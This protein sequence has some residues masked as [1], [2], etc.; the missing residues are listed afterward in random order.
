[1]AEENIVSIRNLAGAEAGT[2]LRKFYGVLDSYYPDERQFGTFVVLNFKD[3]EVVESTE[4]YNFPIATISIKL[5]NRKNS[6]WGVF[7]QSLAELL[8]PD[9]DIKDCV[10]KRMGLYMEEG[11]VFGKDRATGED[12]VGSVWHCFEVEGAAS[13]GV[14][15]ADRAKEL[16]DGKTKAEF[17]KAAY[18]DP[19]IRKDVA[20]QRAITDKSFINSL[21]QTGEFVE[22]ENG[23]FH[24]AGK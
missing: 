9:Q 24:K 10:G 22:D 19:I 7:A 3:V 1:M 17:N 21:V 18:A 5:S 8:P 15:A 6:S 11:H 12:M 2:P 16:L 13:A 14:S 20:L 23:V 4:P